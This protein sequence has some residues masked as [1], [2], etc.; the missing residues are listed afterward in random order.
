MKNVY[1]IKFTDIMFFVRYKESYMQINSARH[2][3]KK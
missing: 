1:T 3:V 2:A